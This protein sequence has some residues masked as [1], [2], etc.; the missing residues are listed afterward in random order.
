MENEKLLLPDIYF[1][2]VNRRKL[3]EALDKKVW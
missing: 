2:D 1:F 3:F